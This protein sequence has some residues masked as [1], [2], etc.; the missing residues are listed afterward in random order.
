MGQP[1][2]VWFDL[3]GSGVKYEGKVLGIASGTGSVFSLIPPQ[4]ATG[5]WIK[6]VRASCQSASVWTLKQFKE[7]PVRLGI[8]AEVDV[9]IT[10]QDL[11]IGRLKFPPQEPVGI[12]SVFDMDMQQIEK[13]IDEII[14]KNLRMS[15]REVDAKEIL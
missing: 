10:N 6:I 5:N 12:T 2:T 9:D 8:S 14:H 7:Y 11:P 15:K 3:Y 1:A 4:N 13:I